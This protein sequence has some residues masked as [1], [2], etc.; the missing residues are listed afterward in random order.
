MTIHVV[1]EIDDQRLLKESPVKQSFYRTIELI[2]VDDWRMAPTTTSQCHCLKMISVSEL[3]NELRAE[4]RLLK[5]RDFD[6]LGRVQDAIP[7]KTASERFTASIKG[8]SALPK[9][10]PTLSSLIVI[11]LSTMI[12]ESLLKQLPSL[13]STVIR[14]N[15][16]LT[17][18]LDTGSTVTLACA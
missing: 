15:G 1:P 5:K 14:N 8:S 9:E 3:I 10:V 7:R 4:S 18:S 12:W 2:P 13:G 16:A 6:A 11:T 17:S